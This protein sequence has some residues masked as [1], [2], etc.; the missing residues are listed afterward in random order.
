VVTSPEAITDLEN[1]DHLLVEGGAQTASAFLAADL[2]DRLLLYRAPI[3]I[4]GGTPALGDIGL[5]GLADAHGR[6]RL[7]DTR[8]LGIDVLAEYERIH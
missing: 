8:M 5:T 2:V 7:R 6:W 3:L 4:G 1:V